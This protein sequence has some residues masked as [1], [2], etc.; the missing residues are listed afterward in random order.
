M[1]D[2]E[3]PTHPDSSFSDQDFLDLSAE[4]DSYIYDAD[5]GHFGLPSD[6]DANDKIIVLVTEKLTFTLG[7]VSPNDLRPVSECTASNEAE[8]FYGAAPGAPVNGFARDAAAM[9]SLYP[10]VIAHEFAHIIQYSR[11]MQ[12]AAPFMTVWELEG[13]AVLAEEITGH[14][15]TGL[16]TGGNYGWA[17]LDAN[18]YWYFNG[19]SILE[20]YFGYNGDSQVEGAPEECGFLAFTDPNYVP[21]NRRNSL[22]YGVTWSL[23]RW[24]SD[25][26]GPSYGGGEAQLHQD[27]IGGSTVGYDNLERVTGTPIETLLARW[28]AALYTDDRPEIGSLDPALTFTSWNLYDIYYN[29]TWFTQYSQLTPRERGFTSYTDN[30]VVRA[31]SA[32]YFRISGSGR[33]P[34]SVRVRDS[35]GEY[36]PAAMQIW[37]VR[38]E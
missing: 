2:D 7:F 36:L 34:T 23:L 24:I 21:C 28:G 29:S 4:F 8:I 3:N 22:H 13:Q 20:N 17:T 12:L 11:R 9:K 38:L 5:V 15:Q 26:Y 35:L 6:I 1:N 14:T 27:L 18:R 16:T 33:D 10:K 25:Q 32:G 19:F 30:L 37:L 31:S